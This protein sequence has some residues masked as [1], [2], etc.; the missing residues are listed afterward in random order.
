MS[1]NRVLGA[2]FALLLLGAAALWCL[3]H[4]EI[5]TVN[6]VIP[7]AP[8]V[9]S[10]PYYALAHILSPAL[11]VKRY[12]DPSRI[13]L[14]QSVLLVAGSADLGVLGEKR[15]EAWVRGGGRLLVQFTRSAA[16][17]P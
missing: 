9:E 1:L 4:L 14:R 7:P 6:R 8:F 13:D 15:L 3:T 17:P 2:A 10:D 16:L 11:S 12:A 5:V